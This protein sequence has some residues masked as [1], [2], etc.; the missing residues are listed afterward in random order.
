MS[1]CHIDINEF[2]VSADE[3]GYPLAF[4]KATFYNRG[5][6]PVYVGEV[7]I[8]PGASYQINYEHPHVIEMKVKVRFVTSATP[9]DA[10]YRALYALE[11]LPRLVI[12][13]M[14]PKQK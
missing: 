8:P 9:V 3:T 4:S 1:P 12:L 13:T 6:I 14:T 7:A 5:N 2:T 10:T 11:N